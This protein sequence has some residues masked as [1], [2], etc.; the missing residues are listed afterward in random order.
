MLRWIIKR[1]KIL[2]LYYKYYRRTGLIKFL[3]KNILKLIGFILILLLVFAFIERN[4]IDFED[5]FLELAKKF[6]WQY[7]FVLFFISESF[8]GL[9]PSDFFIVW[10]KQFPHAYLMLTYLAIISYIGGYISYIIGRN[11][12]RI[13]RINKY[14]SNKFQAHFTTIKKWGGAIIFIAS[15]MPLPFSTFS[16]VAGMMHYPSKNYLLYAIPRI[17]RFYL[18]AWFLFMIF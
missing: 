12:R 17:P 9:I 4:I 18:Y 3:I 10:T 11:I 15:L 13:P 14:F 5:F 16:L 8:L 7:V 6:K 2:F 1:W